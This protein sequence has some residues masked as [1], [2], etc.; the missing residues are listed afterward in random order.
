ML[1]HGPQA[2]TAD[3]G[4]IGDRVMIDLDSEELYVENG[5]VLTR[6]NDMGL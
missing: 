1:T 5:D 6:L 2:L 3:S 4:M